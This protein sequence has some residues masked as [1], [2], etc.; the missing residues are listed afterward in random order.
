[1]KVVL[2]E[3]IKGTGKKGDLVNVSDGYARNFLFPRKLAKEANAQAMNELKNAAE[4]KAFKLKTEMEA[5]QKTA[6]QI[7]GKSVRLFAKAG[8]GG[9]LFGSVTSKEIAE[10]LKKQYHV[11]V[12]KRKIVLD[13]DIKA[14]GTYE[15]EV[16]LYNGISAK[17]Y[18][19]VGEKE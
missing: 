16:K 5:A 2:L 7:N 6:D 13:G 14:F 1:M 10:E 8:Q 4:A 19:V 12:D 18:A 17:I 15:C 3:D 9:R 11:D